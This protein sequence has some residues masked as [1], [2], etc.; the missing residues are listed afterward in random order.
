MEIY[1]DTDYIT[2][3]YDPVHHIVISIAKVPP[4]S[5]EFRDGM[6]AI[7]GAVQRFKTG[8]IVCDVVNLGALLEED[9]IWAAKE[10]RPLAVAS[11]HSRAA[12]VV[13]DDVFTNMSMED[14]MAQADNDV[15]FGY[16]NRMEDAVRWL[17]MPQPDN[18]K[19]SD[20]SKI[21]ADL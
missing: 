5:K 12:F 9:Q 10:W 18:V 20:V 6:M 21:K 11:G 4:A 19:K 15:S 16:F 14:M 17:T 7:L 13:P 3:K 2:V 8:R 1:F